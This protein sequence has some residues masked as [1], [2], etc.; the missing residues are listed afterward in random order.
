MIKKV[1]T[2]FRECKK[3]VN[4][5]FDIIH[6]HTTDLNMG[7]LRLTTKQ[8]VGLQVGS[9]IAFSCLWINNFSEY[10]SEFFDS[11]DV[12][13]SLEGV[14]KGECRKIHPARRPPPDNPPPIF[15]AS[16]PGSGS[17]MLWN[18]IE[19]LTE[20]WTGDEWFQN[21]HSLADE[22]VS[23]KTHYPQSNGRQVPWEDKIS[24]AIVLLRSPLHAIPSYHNYLYEYQNKLPPHSTRAPVEAWIE[25]RDAHFL[26]EL[27][28][29]Q[30]HILYWMKKYTDENI[31]V[32]SY[33]HLVRGP[34][35][36]GDI[37]DFLRPVS[38]VNTPECIFDKVIQYKDRTKQTEN[39][40]SSQN[41]TDT[42]VSSGEEIQ[43]IE[44]TNVTIVDEQAI[45]VEDTSTAQTNEAVTVDDSSTSSTVAITDE[46]PT[47]EEASPITVTD[48]VTT[49]S[50]TVEL[51]AESPVTVTDAGTE[52]S[53]ELE[54]INPVTTDGETTSTIETDSSTENAP[55][56]TDEEATSSVET[57][58]STENTVTVTDEEATSS[59]ESDSSTESPVTVTDEGTTS[60][61]ELTIMTPTTVTDEEVTSS[62]ETDSSTESPVTV[63]DEGETSS[64]EL[65]IITPTTVLDE[66]AV[67]STVT[68]PGTMIESDNTPENIPFGPEPGQSG[69]KRTR[70]PFKERIFKNI[71][72]DE[73]KTVLAGEEDKSEKPVSGGKFIQS[74]MSTPS[75]GSQTTDRFNKRSRFSEATATTTSIDQVTPDAGPFAPVDGTIPI[76]DPLTSD[77]GS[78][79]SDV[80]SSETTPTTTSTPMTTT[81]SLFGGPKIRGEAFDTEEESTE[82]PRDSWMRRRRLETI[83]TAET[84]ETKTA[85]D[86]FGGFGVHWHGIGGSMVAH[87]T[88]DVKDKLRFLGEVNVASNPHSLRSGPEEKPYTARQLSYVITALRVIRNTFPDHPQLTPI[89]E[90]YIAEV[91]DAIPDEST[92]TNYE[93]S[94]SSITTDDPRI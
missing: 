71:L 8:R 53:N 92:A 11:L 46:Q 65:T 37:A 87:Y 63:T 35:S 66:E 76:E 45:S 3:R 16:Y 4:Q 59:V 83:T 13:R 17:K 42:I 86:D 78:L 93:T 23:V 44:G 7:R 5:L 9:I 58:L 57:E 80:E 29:W 15:A 51:S 73:S 27:V 77:Q 79:I 38:I 6:R 39:T 89:I 41:E 33:E 28:A 74:R 48:E 69:L 90:Q 62:V 85:S 34:E 61:D 70:I 82:K 19:G 30:N 49:S 75:F 94:S 50:E 22:V 54:I 43:S 47:S 91:L 24:R 14:A 10:S 72:E 31:L 68:S 32:V 67:S 12:S 81:D 60:P 1:A 55:T 25:W 88:A 21:G 36:I 18:V 64:N 20:L 40:D 26:K 2:S 56:V 84:Q 52:P